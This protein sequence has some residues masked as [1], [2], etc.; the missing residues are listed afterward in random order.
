[1]IIIILGGK[2]VKKI[3]LAEHGNIFV[4]DGFLC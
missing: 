2:R 3:E 4:Q 1:M